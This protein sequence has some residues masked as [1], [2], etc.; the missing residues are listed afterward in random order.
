MLGAGV[1]AVPWPELRGRNVLK[2]V[3]ANA[4]MHSVCSHPMLLP[5]R[6]LPE[7]V[8]V[9]SLSGFVKVVRQLLPEAD[10]VLAVQSDVVVSRQL[11]SQ[12][13]SAVLLAG[14][15]RAISLPALQ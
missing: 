7:A 5:G 4:E 3:G 12:A 14:E 15:S 10:A 9:Y 13:V 1:S 8:S 6:L 2:L 11:L